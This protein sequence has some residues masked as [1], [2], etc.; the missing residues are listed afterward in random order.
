M[1][2][3]I[4]RYRDESKS[5]KASFDAARLSLTQ[6]LDEERK[7]RERAFAELDKQLKAFQAETRA[8]ER[9]DELKAALAEAGRA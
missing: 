8:F 5:L 9:A 6:G 1:D 2:G 4:E 7:A 3:S